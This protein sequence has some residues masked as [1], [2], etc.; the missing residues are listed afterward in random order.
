MPKGAWLEAYA[1]STEEEMLV[2]DYLQLTPGLVGFKIDNPEAQTQMKQQCLLQG[3][4]H[5]L[6]CGS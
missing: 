2:A 6:N 5:I 1:L 3:Q 4:S